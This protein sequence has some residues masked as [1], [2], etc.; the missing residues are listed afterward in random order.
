[1]AQT[2]INIG[3][4]VGIIIPSNLREQNGIKTG[5]KVVVKQAREGILIVPEKKHLAADVDVKFA[6][7]VDE[8]I[9]DHE[10]VLKELA[11]R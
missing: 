4:S 10:D 6:Q 3:N 11:H 2:F 8:F 7:M 9:T 1:M 5:G